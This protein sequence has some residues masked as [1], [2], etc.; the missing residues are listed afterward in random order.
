[1]K[2]RV[3]TFEPLPV[4]PDFFAD[5]SKINSG[6]C[7]VEEKILCQLFRI[8]LMSYSELALSIFCRF[9]EVVSV[10][11]DESQLSNGNCLISANPIMRNC[12]V[13]ARVRES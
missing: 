3:F 2:S 12:T 6:A 9:E 10:L 5:Y 1:L 7:K 8:L 4:G 11:P 13:A